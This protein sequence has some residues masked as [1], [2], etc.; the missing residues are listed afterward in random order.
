MPST[1]SNY[2]SPRQKTGGVELTV[3]LTPGSLGWRKRC[4]VAW[5]ALLPSRPLNTLST[6]FIQIYDRIRAVR[7]RSDRP[8]SR[9]TWPSGKATLFFAAPQNYLKY[10][11][12]PLSLSSAFLSITG[13]NFKSLIHISPMS[14]PEMRKSKAI[15]LVSFVVWNSFSN[16]CQPIL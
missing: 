14:A 4:A 1:S 13:S 16:F 10:S 2:E 12:R 6:R 11:L 5:L 8:P 9:T 15:V 3:Q 7:P